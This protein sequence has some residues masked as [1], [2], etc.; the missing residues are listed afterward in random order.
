[1]RCSACVTQ[2]NISKHVLTQR[3]HAKRKQLPVLCLSYLLASFLITRNKF[4]VV[5]AARRLQELPAPL[6]HTLQAPPVPLNH[7][8]R[9]FPFPLSRYDTQLSTT[10]VAGPTLHL[11]CFASHI[12][13]CECI[14]VWPDACW[15]NRLSELSITTPP[16][17]SHHHPQTVEADPYTGPWDEDKQEVND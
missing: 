17:Q 12:S 8:S 14:G 6:L 1:M 2:K 10:V 11:E 13:P 5:V 4:K 15:P 16:T 7:S 3:R 9:M